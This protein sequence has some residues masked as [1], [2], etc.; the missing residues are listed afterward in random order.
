M[1][2]KPLLSGLAWRAAIIFAAV[3]L[4]VAMLYA[5]VQLISVLNHGITFS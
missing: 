2:S 5:L 4:L 1:P 3:V